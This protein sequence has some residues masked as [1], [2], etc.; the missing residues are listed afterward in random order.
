MTVTGAAVGGAGTGCWF[1]R[2]RER[3]MGERKGWCR[4]RACRMRK[5][6][7]NEGRDGWLAERVKGEA[8]P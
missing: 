2:M 1:A 4:C 8:K 3:R 5:E 7:K 6:K